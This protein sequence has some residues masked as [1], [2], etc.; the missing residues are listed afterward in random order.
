[1]S[2]NIESLKFVIFGN[3]HDYTLL[4]SGD[5]DTQVF[6]HPFVPLNSVMYAGQWYFIVPDENGEPIDPIKDDLAHCTFT[7]ALGD[8]FATEGEIEVKCHYHREY[9]YPEE[10]IVVDKE[11]KQTIEVV[12]HG[13]I[14]RSAGSQYGVYYGSDIYDDGYCFLRPKNVNDLSDVWRACAWDDNTIKS[15]SSL[16]WRVT[17]IG[18]NGQFLKG[19]N[20]EDIT[21]LQYADTSNVTK[22]ECLIEN[23]Q[24]DV[25]LTPLEGWDVSNV[26]AMKVIYGTYGI[27]SLKG[28]GK[29]NVSNLTTLSYAFAYN[30]GLT[31]ISDLKYWDTSNVTN[32]ERTFYDCQALEDLTGLD[33]WDVSNV[34]NMKW[35]FCSCKKLKY[36]EPLKAWKANP[37][38][39]RE[40]FYDCSALIDLTGLKN[41]IMS[42][43]TDMKGMFQNNGK[44]RSIVGLENWDVSSVTNFEAM[45]AG[46]AWIESVAP[47]ANW[48]VSSGTTF[49]SFMENNARLE[50]VDSLSDWDVSNA[51]TLN[52]MF[53]GFNCFYA[54]DIGKNV[55]QSGDTNCHD[56]EGGIYGSA[57]L[58][59]A[60][61]YRKDAS[62]AENWTVNATQKVAFNGTVWANV[63]SWQ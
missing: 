7:P 37:T 2:L 16:Y 8:V 47:L 4:D 54:P 33:G 36:T 53:S 24:K 35:T 17:Q 43:C 11:V 46:G 14:A 3:G 42:N 26:T 18:Y 38:S 21:E 29:W 25:D 45:F 28:L 56:Y 39:A 62:G 63:P 30:F 40:M 12:D 55:W 48:D 57:I 31:D 5:G 32:L 20:I 1:M 13:N 60:T 27:T 9:I 10:T 50:D 52:R 19:N 34:T 6:S 49:A 58:H 22:I 44:L 59:N 23:T 41:F 61:Q 15:V 51:T